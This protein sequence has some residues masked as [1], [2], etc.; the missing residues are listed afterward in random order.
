MNHTHS[1]GRKRHCCGLPIFNLF[2]CS[3]HSLFLYITLVQFHSYCSFFTVPLFILMF[4]RYFLSS[5]LVVF[6][7]LKDCLCLRCV[8]RSCT[9][10]IYYLY[11]GLCQHCR[12][13]NT[14]FVADVGHFLADLPEK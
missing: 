4:Y 12:L 6:C 7:L 14:D 2:N 13:C 8:C 11:L 1:R 5:N 10:T 9:Q 3:V